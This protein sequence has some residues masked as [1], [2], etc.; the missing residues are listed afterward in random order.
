MVYNLQGIGPRL[1]NTFHPAL[2][3]GPTFVISNVYG[4]TK[5]YEVLDELNEVVGSTVVDYCLPVRNGY[6]TKH[7]PHVVHC[8]TARLCNCLAAKETDTMLHGTNP[9]EVCKHVST[10]GG[11]TG[12]CVHTTMAAKDPLAILLQTKPCLF[13]NWSCG[14]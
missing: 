8:G 4:S 9:T 10:W 7:I 6:Q 12:F 14:A 5:L 2:A 11:T 13:T 1:L 3:P